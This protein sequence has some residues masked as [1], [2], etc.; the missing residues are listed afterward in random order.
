MTER[1]PNETIRAWFQDGPAHGTER[2]LEE[3]LASI[4]TTR[5]GAGRVLRLPLWV[6]AAA[7]L[8][9]LLAA[10]LAFGA[11]FRV[12]R[13]IADVPPAPSSS[14]VTCRLEAPVGGMHGFMIGTGFAPDTDVTID[15]TRGN[16]TQITLDRGYSEALH[17][18]RRGSFGV[19]V[20]PYEDDLGRGIAIAHAGCSA[21]LDFDITIAD[22]PPLC[23]DPAVR[24]TPA[25]DGPAYR[26]AVAA[27]RPMAWWHMDDSGDVAADALG[28]H[29]G[30]Y[31]GRIEHAVTSALSDG[32]STFFHHQFPDPTVAR[33]AQ[34]VVLGGDFTI[35]FW[36]LMCH[37][38]DDGDVVVGMAG[39]PVDLNF[40]GNLLHVDTAVG[41]VASVDHAVA[42]LAWEHWAV[43]RRDGALQLYRHGEPDGWGLDA[44]WR[45]PF[46][47]GQIGGNDGG[48]LL[49]YLD[50]L[51]I[52]DHALSPDRIAAHANP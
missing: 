18:D 49:G 42:T 52:Y 41:Q 35:E 14:A 45:D 7:I 19:E 6:P 10:I 28:S 33:L 12:V 40:G 13:P 16:G 20:R 32:G 44:N 1:D 34:P 38:T 25:V 9:L 37:Y 30:A 31:V 15:I 5:Q 50:E 11:G 26:A 4:A 3:T 46:S 23:P 48:N 21:R 43:T 24:T 39:S 17:T 27:D 22:L 2:G 51:A 36:A 8:A 29:P 47:I